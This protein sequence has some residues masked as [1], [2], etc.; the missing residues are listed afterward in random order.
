MFYY[1]INDDNDFREFNEE[2]LPSNIEKISELRIITKDDYI[3]I[4]DT[5]FIPE[6]ETDEEYHNSMIMFNDLVQEIEYMSIED[7]FNELD[8]KDGLITYEWYYFDEHFFDDFGISAYDAARATCFG[9]VNWTDKYIKF[10]AYGNF[11]TT[12]EI[13]YD[14]E[15]EDIVRQ[16]IEENI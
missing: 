8:D 6:Y 2:N 9:E 11:E 13:D 3:D 4:R 10:N 12:D 5:D 1:K 7:I 16:W 15:K 14:D